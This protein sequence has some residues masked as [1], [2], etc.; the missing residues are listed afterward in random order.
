MVPTLKFANGDQI[1]ALGL[2]TWKSDPGEVGAAVKEALRLG[3]RHFDCAAVYGNEKEIGTALAEAIGSGAVKREELWITSKLWNNAH[4]KDDVLPALRQT[5]ADLQLDYLDLYLMHWPIAQRPEVSFPEK[6]ADFLSPDEAPLAETWAALEEAADAGLC[7]HI[8]VSNF[9]PRRL[10]Q[11]LDT[12]RRAPEVNQVE[13]QPLL[14]QNDLLDL[15][16][17]HGVIFTAYSPLGSPDRP[18]RLQRG[19]DPPLMKAPVIE[20]I[21][22][23]HG[24]TPAQVLLAWAVCRGTVVI[25]KSVTPARLQEN[26]AAA[27][28]ELN[29]EDMAALSALDQDHRFLDGAFW[30]MDGSPYTMEYLWG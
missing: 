25:P 19:N 9:S 3:Y 11:L 18:A 17:K 15:C 4:L 6:A 24:I 16:R 20:A 26:L 23:K 30:G 2:G 12:A 13:S 10:Q 27:S 5:L 8:G 22:R 1:P 28:V 29:T 14:A 21:G 7:H